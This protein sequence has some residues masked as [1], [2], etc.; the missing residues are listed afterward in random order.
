VTT[1]SGED[2]DEDSE[3]RVPV[4]MYQTSFGSAIQEALDSYVATGPGES[5]S[6]EVAAPA[7]GKGKKNKKGKRLLFTT[8]MAR[9]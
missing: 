8:N 6:V 3:D 7:V 2:S 4:P 9:K 5:P 1:K